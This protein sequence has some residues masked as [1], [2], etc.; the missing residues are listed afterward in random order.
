MKKLTQIGLAI[1]LA[2]LFAQPILAETLYDEFG[3]K[4]GMTKVVDE[5]IGVVAADVRINSFF[6]NTNIE[7]LKEQLNNQMCAATGGGCEYTGRDMVS[8]H[9]GMGVN[10]AHFN[11]LAEDLQE[12]MT[13]QGVS[14][15]A[16]NKLIAKLAPMQRD[17]V[18]K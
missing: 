15:R 6:K 3:G 2:T 13:R 17:I 18:T 10:T 16:Q 1:S 4:S 8:T 5:F 11:A 14:S 7:R 12:A 9:A